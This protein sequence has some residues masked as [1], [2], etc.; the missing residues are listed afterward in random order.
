MMTNLYFII[1]TIRYS[2]C[3]PTYISLNNIPTIFNT[4]EHISCLNLL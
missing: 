1:I 4:V 3:T 2:D